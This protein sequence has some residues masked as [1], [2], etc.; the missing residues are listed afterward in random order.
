MLGGADEGQ[1]RAA[2]EVLLADK[3]NDGILVI[4]VPTLL[5]KPAAIVEAIVAV[6]RDL[7]SSK[8]ILCCLFGEASLGAAYAVADKGGL[9]TYRFPE[10]AVRTFQIMRQ[11]A[12][13]LEKD[14]SAPQIPEGLQ[15]ARA[16]KLLAA[17]RQSGVNALDAAAGGAVLEAYGIRT[18]KDMLATSAD[19]AARFAT[20]IGFPVALKLASPDILHKTEVGGVL[21]NV[22]NEAAVR[23]GF[24]TILTRARSA[25]PE[26]DIRGVQV[27]QMIP[28]G[29]EIIIGV[30]RDPIFGPLVMFGLGGVYVEVLAD[31]SFRLAPLSRQDAEEMIAEVRSAKLLQGLRGAPP[32]DRPALVDTLVRVGYLA[33][34]CPEI[35]ELDINPL[36]VLAEGQGVLAADVR[37]ILEGA[38]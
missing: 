7:K 12:A 6:I 27:Q 22:Q 21:L 17:T 38:V 36:M 31:V 16:R 20:Q 18:P 30:K 11:R 29:Q 4:L 23:E 35:A 37:I 33:S 14:H 9:P 8:P 28:G 10:D 1:F 5:N 2:L 3:G 13:W 25:H 34:Q 32:A 15:P 19:E 24:D 26:A